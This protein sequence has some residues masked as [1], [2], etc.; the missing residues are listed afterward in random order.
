M[1][2]CIYICIYVYIYVYI[3]ICIYIAERKRDEEGLATRRRADAQRELEEKKAALAKGKEIEKNESPS[4]TVKIAVVMPDASRFQLS[5][6]VSVNL[7]VYVCVCVC[8][9]V[10]VKL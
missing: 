5:L 10:C 4:D 6:L 1:Y 3:Y 2:I 9:T 7:C 8:V